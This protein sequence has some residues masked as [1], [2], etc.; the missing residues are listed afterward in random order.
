MGNMSQAIAWNLKDNVL[1]ATDH[2][3]TEYDQDGK[4]TG[5]YYEIPNS[6]IGAIGNRFAYA[7]GGLTPPCEYVKKG[8]GKINEDISISE[9]LEKITE[10]CRKAHNS[11]INTEYSHLQIKG[12]KTIGLFLASHDRHWIFE[13]ENNFEPVEYNEELYASVVTVDDNDKVLDAIETYA[14][15][16]QTYEEVLFKTFKKISKDT[17]EISPTCD[18]Y[19]ITKQGVERFNFL[20]KNISGNTIKT[21]SSGE[22][23][24]LSTNQLKSYNSTNIKNGFCIEKY[25]NVYSGLMYQGG[26]ILG[27]MVDFNDGGLSIYANA[28]TN[29]NLYLAANGDTA[30]VDIK[31]GGQ[32]RLIS[33]GSVLLPTNTYVGSVNESNEIATINDL[34]GFVS[35][36]YVDS[37]FANINHNH[38]N[39]Y[40]KN[41]TPSD[42]ISISATEFGIIVRKGEEILGQINYN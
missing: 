23:L 17:K 5:Q 26:S 41:R 7:M 15:E 36:S 32:I 30:R 24:E 2:R 16:S 27:G 37:N 38:G 42:N 19:R 10:L 33:G 6:K 4:P 21:A 31:A 28:S 34:S 11:F 29:K 14:N 8:I 3:F 22:R 18:I 13:V 12:F 1:L 40:I 9:L 20:T 35:K 25:N 39:Y